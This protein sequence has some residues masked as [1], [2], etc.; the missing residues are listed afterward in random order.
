MELEHKECFHAL[1]VPISFFFFAIKA[2]NAIPCL[3]NFK[4][5]ASSEGEVM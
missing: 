4:G 1:V 2:V 3:K 5:S